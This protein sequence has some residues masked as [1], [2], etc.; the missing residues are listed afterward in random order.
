MDAA[1]T[2]NLRVTWTKFDRYSVNLLNEFT[3]IPEAYEFRK[4]SLAHD[5][6]IILNSHTIKVGFF[7]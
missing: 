1:T 7:N 5:H 4:K 6:N 2:T 3:F